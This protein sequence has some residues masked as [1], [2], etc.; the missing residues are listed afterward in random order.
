MPIDTQESRE[1]GGH[2][3]T[4][5]QRTLSLQRAKEVVARIADRL[6]GAFAALAPLLS[7]LRPSTPEEQMEGRL[8]HTSR[9]YAPQ[10]ARG[11]VT[12][13]E[14]RERM[15]AREMA[16]QRKDGQTN[17]L[18][19]TPRGSFSPDEIESR[20]E[21][22]LLAAIDRHTQREGPRQTSEAPRKR[23]RMRM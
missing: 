4:T 21:A 3:P 17:P 20:A 15:V 11:D 19:G 8:A 6:D 2:A 18:H 10:I 22:K 9:V 1:A 16:A 14:A 23:A 5:L 7:R 12:F 13:S